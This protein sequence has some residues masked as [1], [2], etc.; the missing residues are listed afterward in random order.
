M[1][2]LY[3]LLISTALLCSSAAVCSAEGNIGLYEKPIGI[4]VNHCVVDTVVNPIIENGRTLV[5]LRLISESLG[6]SVEWEEKTR[7]VSVSDKY[8]TLKLTVDSY[9]YSLNGEVCHT[10]TAPTI[11]DDLTFVPIRLVAESFDCE[12]E[13]GEKAASWLNECGAV[14][15]TEKMPS[16]D[17]ID[18]ERLVDW[19][20]IKK[21]DIDKDLNITNLEALTVINQIVNGGRIETDFS[22]SYY[23]EMLEKLERFDDSEKGLLLGLTFSNIPIINEDEF[24]GMDLRAKLTNYN[25]LKC[26]VRMTG[27]THSCTDKSEES[28]F[29]EMSQVYENALKKG[30]INEIDMS[31]SDEAITRRD[32]LTMLY[33]SLYVDFL[34][35]GPG[36]ALIT[37]YRG[38]LPVG[39]YLSALNNR[40]EKI[41]VEAVLDDDM[42]LHWSVPE[43]YQGCQTRI[44]GYYSDYYAEQ[45]MGSTHAENRIDAKDLIYYA[46]KIDG[47]KLESLRCEYENA[48]ESVYFD[49]DLSKIKTVTEGSE[50]TPGKYV[51]FNGEW[52]PKQITL[53]DGQSFKKGSYYVL[54]SY[55][56]DY[57]DSLSVY[58]CVWS[59]VFRTDEDSDTYINDSRGGTFREIGLDNIYIREATVTGSVEEGFT[60]HVTPRSKSAF[61]VEG[62]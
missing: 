41:E 24:A 49:I 18:L 3:C 23:G 28:G 14:Y 4:Y 25:A 36:G 52:A 47:Y 45:L 10:D 17:R 6:Y 39:S 56:F 1:K 55:S 50:L 12:V 42:S 33:K 35:G 54:D 30:I 62:E 43:K 44:Y 22:H 31:G 60:I 46:L 57:G 11:V 53:A 20:I 15:V 61:A 5:P 21:E 27:N 2:K 58:N 34:A 48:E 16:D 59:A 51:H 40:P 8:R 38:G 9:E 7:T 13:W 32:F 29:I 37:N 19:N 26:L